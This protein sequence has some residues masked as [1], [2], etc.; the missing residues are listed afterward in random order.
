M[1][2]NRSSEA[3]Y[4]LRGLLKLLALLWVSAMKSVVGLFISS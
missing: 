3:N 1:M 2:I 4:C